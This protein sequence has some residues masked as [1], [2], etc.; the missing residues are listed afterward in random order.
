MAHTAWP[1][2]VRHTEGDLHMY[3]NQEWHSYYRQGLGRPMGSSLLVRLYHLSWVL[4][5]RQHLLWFWARVVLKC[6]QFHLTGDVPQSLKAFVLLA[7]SDQ[8]A[9]KYLA[10]HSIVPRQQ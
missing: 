8:S 5:I 9:A 10:M 6:M 1:C 4:L 2:Y 7:S 3:I